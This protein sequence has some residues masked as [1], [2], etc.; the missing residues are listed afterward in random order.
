MLG[1][2]SLAKVVVWINGF[3]I[4]ALLMAW[5]TPFSFRVGPRFFPHL[6]LFCL[7][8]CIILAL[9]SFLSR[10]VVGRSSW[11]TGA[12]IKEACLSGLVFIW[13]LFVIYILIPPT[14][15]N[16]LEIFRISDFSRSLPTSSYIEK[17]ILSPSQRYEAKLMCFSP[18]LD[19]P[20]FGFLA[21]DRMLI[22]QQRMAD[23]ELTSCVD[24]AEKSF[25]WSDGEK[26]LKWTNSKGIISP[27]K[28]QVRIF[29]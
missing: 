4:G 18:F 5:L 22:F 13:S 8:F 27:E 14:T 19:G 17:M 12:F 15:K 25:S 20:S 11:N 21:V 28:G 26:T 24:W 10:K 6:A 16:M 2:N 23:F 9:V 29:D 1:L 3:I 7:T